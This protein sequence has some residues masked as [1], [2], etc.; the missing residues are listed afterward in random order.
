MDVPR[1]S[2]AR[3]QSSRAF[4]TNRQDQLPSGRVLNL[5]CLGCSM[6]QLLVE[7]LVAVSQRIA[8]SFGV[9]PG[10]DPQPRHQRVG[11]ESPWVWGEV[12]GSLCMFS[13]SCEKLNSSCIIMINYAKPSTRS[14]LKHLLVQGGRAADSFHARDRGCLQHS[15]QRNSFELRSVLCQHLLC[16]QTL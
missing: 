12:S 15:C 10:D 4:A 2:S 5:K 1:V 3:R 6:L 9:V 16:S 11:A 13:L 8:F 7:V 14:P